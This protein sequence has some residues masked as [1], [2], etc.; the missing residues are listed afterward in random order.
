M[1]ERRSAVAG[2]RVMSATGTTTLTSGVVDPSSSAMTVTGRVPPRN[3]AISSRGATVADSPMRW[4]GRFRRPS[5]RSRDRA[6][7][8]PRFSPAKEWISSTTTVS[9]VRSV[10][11]TALVSMR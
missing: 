7:W 2:T 5:S 3:R 10:C 8:V 11:R 4:A 6:R 1:R 9:T